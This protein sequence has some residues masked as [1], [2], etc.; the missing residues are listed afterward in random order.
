MPCIIGRLIAGAA[1]RSGPPASALL[2]ANHLR[3]HRRE[4]RPAGSNRHL[5]TRV[6]AVTYRK[7]R[8]RAAT[9]SGPLA[10]LRLLKDRIILIEIRDQRVVRFGQSHSSICR[11]LT[12]KEI[13]DLCRRPP[14]ARWL[15]IHDLRHHVTRPPVRLHQP[16]PRF[17]H[18]GLDGGRQGSPVLTA[19]RAQVMRQPRSEAAVCRARP[20]IS[21]S[22]PED[23]PIRGI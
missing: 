12:G 3:N 19:A 10:S 22:T 2:C 8:E 13:R 16:R 18:R 17:W 7:C 9:V 21:T 20:A 11:H 6:A 15:G 5:N 1:E 23:R 14:A 4:D